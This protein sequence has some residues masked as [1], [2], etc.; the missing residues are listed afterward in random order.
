[1]LRQFLFFCIVGTVGFVVDSGALLGLTQLMGMHHLPGR[2][3]SFLFAATITWAL[4]RRFTF[5][6]VHRARTWLPYVLA[7]AWVQ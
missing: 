7:T 2:V 6:A 3:F 1:M 5:R 4:N